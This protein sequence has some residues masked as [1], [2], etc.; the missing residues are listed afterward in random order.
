[1][2]KGAIYARESNIGGDRKEVDRLLEEQVRWGRAEAERLGVEVVG[3]YKDII[4]GTVEG[5]PELDR[6]RADIPRLGIQVVLVRDDS[7]LGREHQV[8]F[9]IVNEFAALGAP[10]HFGNISVGDLTDADQW[11]VFYVLTGATEWEKRRLVKKMATG[12]KRARDKGVHFAKAP[13]HFIETEDRLLV[14]DETA[15]A[16]YDARAAGEGVHAVAL[17]FRTHDQDVYRTVR[18]VAAYRSGQVLRRGKARD[19]DRDIGHA[20]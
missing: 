11:F 4:T 15:E 6:L 19:R 20:E 16:I 18:R 3:V 5:R 12:A 2:K 13:K 7:R 10:I 1:M 8:T 14:P 9:N 17:R